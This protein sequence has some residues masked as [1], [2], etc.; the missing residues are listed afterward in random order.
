MGSLIVVHNGS[1]MR[2]VSSCVSAAAVIILCSVTGSICKCTIAEHSTSASSYRGEILGAI[3]A[4]LILR[5]AVTGRTGPFPMVIED[6]DNNGVVLHGNSHSR[7][8]SSTQTQADVLRIVKRLIS[9]QPF[10]TNF[11]YVASHSDDIKDWSSCTIKE[12]LNIKVDLLAKRALLHAH[13]CH[14]YFDGRFPVEDFCVYTSGHKVSGPIKPAL[15]MHWGR[16]EAKRFLD[17]KHIVASSDFDTIWWHGVDLAMKSVP[18]TYRIFVTKQVSGWC[19]TNSKVSLW[20]STITNTCPNCGTVKETSKHVTR[21]QHVGRVQIFRESMSDVISHLESA[22]LD[23]DLVS[24][25]ESYLMG[26]GSISMTS[27]N[28]RNS[29]FLSLTEAHDSLGWD[30][31]IEGRIPILLITT[32]ER[33]LHEWN[34]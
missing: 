30:C 18:K 11:F 6:C 4:Q 17:F 20:D 21:C 32:A 27:C 3:I 25:Y 22:N 14:E 15:E 12:R 2:E 29:Q 5:A 1:F 33:Y 9:I 34:P 13:S 24:I 7:T 10:T 8:L 19:G 28:P 23:P 16:A 31:F 26:Q